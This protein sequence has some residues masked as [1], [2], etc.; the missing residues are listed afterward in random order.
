MCHS[1][2]SSI[3]FA[4][5][6]SL[7]ADGLFYKGHPSWVLFAFYSLMECTQALQHFVVDACGSTP[8]MV[9]SYCAFVLVVTQPLLWNYYRWSKATTKKEKAV[10][11]AMMWL[12]V[13]WMVLFS[14]R[15]LPRRN[16]LLKGVL[17]NS[18]PKHE[19]MVAAETC[20]R[21]GPTHLY[22][23]FPLLDFNGV[24]MNW[25]GYLLLWFVPALFEKKGLLKFI[26]WLA[27]VAFVN[28]MAQNIHE[29]PTIWCLLSLP[30]L[31]A[32]PY[33]DAGAKIQK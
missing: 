24:E 32:I 8:N 3:F 29:V 14:A 6:G 15:L 20:T 22:W 18:L 1:L 31:V 16:S 4:A 12:S 26:Y 27:Q 7:V 17:Y 25:G 11:A 19:I 9:L 5:F 33:F 2:G 13:F 10:F 30:I 23:T 28:Y 21:L